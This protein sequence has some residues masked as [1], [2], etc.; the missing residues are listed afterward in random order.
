MV[1]V[2]QDQQRLLD[3]R[4]AAFAFDVGDKTDTASVMLILGCVQP[5]ARRIFQ[6][7]RKLG[8]S[9]HLTPEKFVSAR[10]GR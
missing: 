1:K 7:D 3:Q 9:A 2:L 6:G 4:V 5:S 10:K 8:F